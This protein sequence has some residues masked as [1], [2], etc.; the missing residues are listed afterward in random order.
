MKKKRGVLEVSP[1][2]FLRRK[3]VGKKGNTK[4]FVMV[5]VDAAGVEH[6]VYTR[7]S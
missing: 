5:V 2:L 1:E 3:I 6:D 7:G 4:G